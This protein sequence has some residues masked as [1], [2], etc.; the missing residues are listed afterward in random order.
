MTA[1]MPANIR[2]QAVKAALFLAARDGWRH[3][4][5]QKIAEHADIG[6]VELHDY[7]D[8]RFDILA[9]YGKM[10]DRRMLSACGPV[11]PSLSPRDR[12]FDLVMERFDILNED[13]EGIIAILKDL[14]CEPRQAV[15][16]LPH[17]GRS[18]GWMADAAGIETSG[19][20]GA[21]KIMGLVAVYLE[22]IRH[23]M[24]DESPDMAKTM[25]ALDKNLSRAEQVAGTLRLKRAT[26]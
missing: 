15:I 21:V 26:A 24:D 4:T 3:V 11:D 23:W 1:K 18:M 6:L 25:A 10:I 2:D 20:Q 9:A 12:L 14:R 5:F 17:L 19:W 7:F 22:T 13:R 8:D 16:S